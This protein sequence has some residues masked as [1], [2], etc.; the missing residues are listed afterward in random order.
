MEA[1]DMSCNKPE[2]E[3]LPSFRE[4]EFA[5]RKK[6]NH[7]RP[8]K[9]DRPPEFIQ[10]KMKTKFQYLLIVLA[11]LARIHQAA[12]Q[13]TAF[14][15]EGQLQN[16]GSPANGLYDFQFSLS[17]AASGGSQIGNTVTNLG[18][19][20]TNGVFTTT[21]DFGTVFTGNPTWLAISVCSN[22]LGSYVNLTPL[23]PIRPVVYAIFANTAS[24]LSGTIPATQLSGALGNSQLANN[25]INVTAGVG[26]AGGGAV[27]LGGTTT[28]NNTGVLSVNGNSDII[29]LTENG[30][31]TLEDTATSADTANTMVKRDGSGNF[32]AGTITAN[33]A[34]NAAT[35]T[36]AA[37]LS[38]NV[39]D[40]QLSVNVPLLNGTNAFAGTNNFAGVMVATNANNVIVGAFTGNLIGNVTGN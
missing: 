39:S 5:K 25:S 34:G 33:L 6:M 23:Q 7:Q 35:A 37:N 3:E 22:G 24:N 29:A 40:V 9:P 13:G 21:L 1:S 26:L 20:V 11:G 16:N 28:L 14:A 12:A 31:V 32:S 8:T 4:R 27:A 15:Y 30:A 38:G 36:T 10:S 17:D 2:G 18:V 19:G